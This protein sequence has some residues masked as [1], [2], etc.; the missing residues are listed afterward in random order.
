[1]ATEIA[2]TDGAADWL[3]ERLKKL[4]DDWHWSNEPSVAPALDDKL[5]LREIMRELD[6]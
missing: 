5:Y 3:K 4:Q 1:M 2:L 6:K